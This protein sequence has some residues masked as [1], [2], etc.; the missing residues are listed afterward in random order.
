MQGAFQVLG[1]HLQ[2][3]NASP[4]LSEPRDLS[5]RDYRVFAC[6]VL[7]LMATLSPKCL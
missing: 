7:Q 3:M 2:L 4:Y 5:H 1:D 6:L